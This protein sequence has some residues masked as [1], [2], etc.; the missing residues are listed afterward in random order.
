MSKTFA[1]TAAAAALGNRA[2]P[3]RLEVR[4]AEVEPPAL[5]E[6]RKSLE[7][8]MKTVMDEREIDREKIAE[9]QKRGAVDPLTEEKMR[10]VEAGMEEVRKALADL[11]LKAKRSGAAKED[12]IPGADPEYRNAFHSFLRRGERSVSK[13]HEALL[14]KRAMQ[15]QDNTDGGY[16]T[17]PELDREVAKLAKDMSPARQ[18]FSVRSIGSNAFKKPISKGGTASGWVGETGGRPQTDA[19]TL[20]EINIVTHE[21]YAMPGATQTILDDAFINIEQFIAEEAVDQFDDQESDAFFT[22]NGVNKPMGLLSIGTT[23]ETGATRAA[24]GKLGIIKTGSASNF[25]SYLDKFIDLISRLR[26]KYRQNARWL[27][28]ALT[29]A[30]IR[31]IKDSDNNYM[32]QPSNQLGVPASFLG[33]PATVCDHMPDIADGA[34]PVTFGDYKRAYQIIDRAG[35]RTLR[36]PYTAKPYVLFYMTKRVGGG[37]LITEA[38]KGLQTAA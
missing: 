1:I 28:N 37:H 15:A 17:N 20:G 2:K 21:I 10:K 23:E 24:Q 7:K 6:V 36:D 34:I 22:G 30:P 32:W 14:Q 35:I 12:D 4:D 9:L 26:S 18:L 8:F 19:S 5:A 29:E 31:K 3:P 11:E 16:L 25:G 13:E 33:Y 38:F 27:Y